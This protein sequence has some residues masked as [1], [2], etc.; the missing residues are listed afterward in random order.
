MQ[1]EANILKAG[2]VNT[3]DAAIRTQ[4]TQNEAAREAAKRQV[5]ENGKKLLADLTSRL[6]Q[7][8][9]RIAAMKGVKFALTVIQRLQDAATGGMADMQAT[10]LSGLAARL[11]STGRSETELK[12][13]KD[14]LQ[15]D[16]VALKKLD[17]DPL[18]AIERKINAKGWN[19][20]FSLFTRECVQDMTEINN[21]TL[22]VEAQN[23][24]RAIYDQLAGLLGGLQTRLGS[25]ETQIGQIA[26]DL[27]PQ[28]LK[29]GGKLEAAASGYELLREIE[30]DFSAYYQEHASHINPATAF[31]TMIPLQA[32]KNLE[33]FSTW[34]GDNLAR[35]V[36]SHSASFFKETL[37]K[38]SLLT[39]LQ[40]LALKQGKNPQKYIEQQLESLIAYCHPFWVYYKDR[41]LDDLEGHSIIG[42]EDEDTPLLPETYRGSGLYEVKTT[43]FRDRIDVVRVQHGMPAFLL[44]GMEEYRVVY[45]EKRKGMDPLHILPG[46]EDAP[47]LLPQ[48]GKANFEM[49]AVAFAFGY[50]VQA[51]TWFYYDPEKEKKLKNISPDKKFRLAQGRGKA[52]VEFSKKEAWVRAVEEKVN[53]EIGDMGNLKAKELLDQWIADLE[54]LLAQTK[55]DDISRK[56]YQEEIKAIRAYKSRL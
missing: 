50:I 33:A 43:G 6:E 31:Q 54:A 23:Q 2:D 26:R 24:A 20:K 9:V 40:D 32:S 8:I 14:E 4:E 11:I 44:Q 46:M 10:S 18:D 15:N 53:V 28:Y 37:E 19:K 56:Q 27:E 36:V 39:M 51:S 12:K 30:M 21:I 35:E 52:A 49:F 16:L 38:T 25:C 41:G 48:E 1:Y 47:D 55:A 5:Q 29:M 3:A 13:W 34:I 45:E 7:E 17:D 42:V 22:Q